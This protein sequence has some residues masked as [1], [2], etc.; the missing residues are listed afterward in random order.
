[1]D[2]MPRP[3]AVSALSSAPTADAWL[4]DLG[5]AEADK[6]VIDP[7][8]SSEDAARAARFRAP[9]DRRRFS[10]GR[11]ALRHILSAYAGRSAA[12]LALAPDEQGRPRLAD[13]TTVDFNSSRSGNY[14]LI[15]VTRHGR[16]GVDIERI[17]SDFPWRML[18]ETFF[19]RNENSQLAAL[20]EARALAGFFRAWVSK[21]ACVK[22]W[23]MGLSQP[24]DGFDVNA[25][26]D[27]QPAVLGDRAHHP[28]LWLHEIAAPA[29]YAAVLASDHPLAAVRLTTTSHF[30]LC[31][32]E[33]APLSQPEN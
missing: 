17:Q 11:G 33:T 23:G 13:P 24:L 15:G 20:P 29:G 26:P 5:L 8:Y 18:A 22:A 30:R 31:D 21:E 6:Q 10:R 4:V 9:A 19:S 7:T 32:S 25:D 3:E 14:A 16:V 28:R 1:M 12:S 27:G 2:H